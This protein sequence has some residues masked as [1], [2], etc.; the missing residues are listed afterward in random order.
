MA[1][2][3]AAAAAERQTAQA[4]RKARRQVDRAFGMPPEEYSRLLEDQGGGCAICG[5]NKMI[6]R[7]SNGIF[8]ADLCNQTGVIRGLL[9]RACRSRVLLILEDQAKARRLLAYLERA[10]SA[11]GS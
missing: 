8:V 10:L 7:R 5:R 9:C 3:T 11:L 6:G 2:A 1:A 4:D